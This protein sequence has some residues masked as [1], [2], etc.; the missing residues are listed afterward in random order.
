MV[1]E[2]ILQQNKLWKKVIN[3]ELISGYRIEQTKD[4]YRVTRNDVSD[5]HTHLKSLSG[6]RNAIKYVVEKKIPRNT[7]TYYLESLI[8][9][10]DDKLYINK[11]KELI[12]TRKSKGKKQLYFNPHKK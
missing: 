12:K 2:I 1:T 6:S 3:I 11:I 10:S 9:L 7:N 4:G 5:A 8:R